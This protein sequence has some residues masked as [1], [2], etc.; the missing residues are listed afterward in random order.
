[1][2]YIISCIL[3]FIGCTNNPVNQ[4]EELKNLRVETTLVIDINT[5]SAT[6][7]WT[8]SSSAEGLLYYGLS[9]PDTSIYIPISATFHRVDLSH[10]QE[11]TEYQYIPFCDQ[12]F[13][14]IFPLVV[15][16]KFS[17]L[18]KPPVPT[19]MTEINNRSIFIFGGIGSS[20]NFISQV[21][22]YD[23]IENQIYS[24]ITRIPTPRSHGGVTSING[25]IYLIGGLF[26][27]EL[28][29]I[30][31]TG[32]VEEYNPETKTW[33]TMASMPTPLQG[34]V[35]GKVE[36]SIYILGGSTTT[37]IQTGT[38][39]NTVYKFNPF[40]GENGTWSVLVSANAISPK[41]D[42]GGCAIDG[43]IF[44][45]GGRLSSDGSVQSTNESYIPTS[46]SNTNITETAL[47]LGRHG[48]AST[49]YVPKSTDPFPNDPKAFLIA[50]GST[51]TSLLQPIV[52]P[53]SSQAFDYY[54]PNNS[55]QNPNTMSN[56]QSLPVSLYY[57]AMEISYSQRK[58][59]LFGGK[60]NS[61]MLQTSIYSLDLSNP[62]GSTWEQVSSQL[63]IARYAHM[64]ISLR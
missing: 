25:K 8:C 15:P 56:G 13:K 4:S 60:N 52:S 16:I 34:F 18:P 63:Q 49:C 61:S 35:L 44:Y 54:L 41:I 45:A 27:N 62:L 57:P 38:L 20:G 53:S 22:Q 5:N 47:N 3:F 48:V 29:Q 33:R 2:K 31:V 26:Q 50:G 64:V 21:E 36:N 6:I 59:F 12:E 9:H 23:P 32:I 39:T 30:G 43:T 28:N 1:L 17:T 58:A 37:N 10:L 11:N 24:D 46:N 19:S 7:Y 55:S 42:M 40:Q 14:S 51:N